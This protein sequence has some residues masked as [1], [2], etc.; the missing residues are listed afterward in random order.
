[1]NKT[2]KLLFLATLGLLATISELSAADF[3]RGPEVS[4]TPGKLCELTVKYRYAEKIAYCDRD[5]EYQLKEII[6]AE[7]DQKFGY[8]IHSMPRADFKIDHYI[9]LCAGGSNDITNLWPQHKS[10]YE[11]TDPLEPVVCAKMAQGLLKQSDA[12]SYIK[13]AKAHPEQTKQILLELQEVR[14]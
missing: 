8:K 14:R 12:V 1:M 4:I 10:I 6:I 2:L 5:V 7:Y 13:R 9:P 3:P 11:Q